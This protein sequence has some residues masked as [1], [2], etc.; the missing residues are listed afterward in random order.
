MMFLDALDPIRLDA[1]VS[2]IQVGVWRWCPQEISDG[3]G[4]NSIYFLGHSAIEAAKMINEP[5]RAANFS[6]DHGRRL[7]LTKHH[8]LSGPIE[9]FWPRDT[10][11]TLTFSN[12]A[13]QGHLPQPARDIRRSLTE[14]LRS[15]RMARPVPPFRLPLCLDFGLL[16]LCGR[17]LVRT[18]FSKCGNAT[19][20]VPSSDLKRGDPPLH[21][22]TQLFL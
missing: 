14:I 2:Q 5:L 15:P 18:L 9:R 16:G 11:N 13:S 17:R 10:V 20:F 19:S 12:S 6:R 7:F 21:R 8:S 22:H 1:L 4:E 3:I